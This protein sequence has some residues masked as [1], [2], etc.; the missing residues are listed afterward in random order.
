MKTVLR[1]ALIYLFAA[2]LT[3]CAGANSS[4]DPTP[5]VTEQPLATPLSNEP[6][7]TFDPQNAG[8]VT[9][10]NTQYGFVFLLPETWQGYTIVE[11]T[12]EGTAASG[13]LSGKIAASGPEI[14]IR[15]P[16]W[17]QETPRQDIPILVF[18]RTQWEALEKET[19]HL[20]AAPIPPLELGR[21]S[22]YVFALPARY[23]YE[24]LFGYEEVESILSS[25]PLKTIEPL[26]P[27]G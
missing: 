2:L 16:N 1:V 27:K 19:F 13:E 8:K 18:E 24:Y 5:A 21:N 15:H 6:E 20:G 26:T 7:H 17:S 9:M 11:T 12:W 10:Y 3:G 25:Q 23:N 14:I 4:N 22:R